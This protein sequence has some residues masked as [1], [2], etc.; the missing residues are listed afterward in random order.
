M[1]YYGDDAEPAPCL[2]LVLHYLDGGERRIP[3][4]LSIPPRWAPPGVKDDPLQGEESAAPLVLQVRS[5]NSEFQ[6][7]VPL[8]LYRVRVDNPEPMR[9]L[10]SVGLYAERNAPYV[11]A[12][13]ADLPAPVSP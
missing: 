5:N 11:A 2:S 3:V 8:R 13:T 12:I 4:T 6:G 9:A 1:G 10:A 7:G